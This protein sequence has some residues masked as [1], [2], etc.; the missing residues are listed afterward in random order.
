[1]LVGYI[2]FVKKR[3]ILL[4]HNADAVDPLA[5]L[6]FNFCYFLS[7]PSQLDKG[8][9]ALWADFP[10]NAEVDDEIWRAFVPEPYKVLGFSVSE[11]K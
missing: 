9:T 3:V 7:D 1:M 2:L 4:N 6:K 8:P 5:H 11:R 10:E